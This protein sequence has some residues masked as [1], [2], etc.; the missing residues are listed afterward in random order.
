[1]SWTA[2]ELQAL[3]K[4]YATGKTRVT[5]D[6]KTVEYDS[7]SGLLS[8]IRVIEAEISTGSGKKKPAA[9]FVRFSRERR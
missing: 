9:G 7:A 2:G 3:K 5:Y 4:A 1:M 8:R 6:G